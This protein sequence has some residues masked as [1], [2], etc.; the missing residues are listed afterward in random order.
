MKNTISFVAL[1][2]IFTLVQAQTEK[3]NVRLYV[4]PGDKFRVKIN[5]DLQP[6]ANKFYLDPGKKIKLQVWAPHHHIFDTTIVASS[7]I[8]AIPK[9]LEPK[10][11]FVTYFK[12]QEQYG[13]HKKQ[14]VLGAIG[15]F[16]MAT[17]SFFNYSEV[18]RRKLDV[19]IAEDA[20][21]FKIGRQSPYDLSRSRTRYA[22]AQTFQ[23]F[24]YFA[25]AGLG[26]YT[27]TRIKKMKETKPTKLP[28]DK[29]FIVEGI[30]LGYTKQTGYQFSTVL[31][32]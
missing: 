11:E 21:K 1:F 3:Y 19:I 32:F 30:G 28:E 12:K 9:I 17:M 20:E 14:M 2:F 15:T 7:E 27:Y 24:S 25:I 5:G 4:Q 29:R 8:I 26:Y 31:K 23:V 10:E 16:G 13:A 22:V 6:E 18:G